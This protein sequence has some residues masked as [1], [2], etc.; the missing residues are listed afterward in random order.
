LV[1]A[2]ALGSQIAI[3]LARSGFG[4][5]SIFDH[6]QLL[7]HNMSRHALSGVFIGHNKAESLAIEIGNILNDETVASS[8]EMNFLKREQADV[9][10]ALKKADV[11]LDCSA[12]HA[13]SR[14]L[15][16][17]DYRGARICI[18]LATRGKFLVVLS[19]GQERL[20]RL[21][22]LEMQLAV[23]VLE[24]E[25]LHRVF[26]DGSGSVA[27]AGSCRD[28]SVQMAQDMVAAHAGIAAR[29]VRDKALSVE[30]SVSLWEWSDE[31][32]SVKRHQVAIHRVHV[33]TE[34]GWNVRISEHAI[35][36]MRYHRRCRLPNETGG[37]LLG[38]VDVG[39]RV[40]YVSTIIPSPS[41]SMEWPNAYIRGIHGL[42]ERV[43]AANNLTGGSLS[44]VGEWHSHPDGAGSSPS[45]ADEKGLAGIADQM[46]MEG[47][48][49][50]VLIQSEDA[51][52]YIMLSLG[53]EPAAESAG[54][55]IEG[56]SS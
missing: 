12:S 31:D 19:E 16:H 26:D 53:I 48:P 40:I 28:L 30:P 35:Y 29:F 37:V 1:G 7:P 43:E 13:V 5:W 47:L 44:Y 50:L 14:E 27:Y 8:F 6:D 46:A 41:D 42:F 24:S 22:D 52:P 4:T 9:G 33:A 34:N 18:F 23:A 49:A 36:M 56:F 10:E 55:T 11:L 39:N 15:A 21:D 32:V 54:P 51:A 2:G 45:P 38:K 25:N 3:N 20:I 17:A